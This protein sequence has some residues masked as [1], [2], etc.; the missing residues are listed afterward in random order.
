[1]GSVGLGSGRYLG[2]GFSTV[3]D[4]LKVKSE[5]SNDFCPFAVA[6][7]LAKFIEGEMD[8]IMVVNFFG[9]NFVTQFQPDAVQ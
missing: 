3:L 6:K 7:F 4:L 1:M 2:A 5:P 8:N 9:S